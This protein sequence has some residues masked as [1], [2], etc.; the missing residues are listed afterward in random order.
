MILHHPLPTTL[1]PN[2]TAQIPQ[3]FKQTSAETDENRRSNIIVAYIGGESL[4]L[5]NLLMT[6]SYCEVNLSKF[7]ITFLT[8][9]GICI[10]S[11]HKIGLSAVT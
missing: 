2:T 5:T 10:R 11:F 7:N 6:H 3:T 1:N 4:N 9:V 8:R